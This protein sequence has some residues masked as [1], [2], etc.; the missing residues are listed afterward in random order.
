MSFHLLGTS[1]ETDLPEPIKARL[2]CHFLLTRIPDEGLPE[3]LESL[4]GMWM[5]YQT[6]TPH[7]P[8]LP[9]ARSVP[10]RLTGSYAEPVY[11]VTED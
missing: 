2:L 10:A 3:A 7:P 9:S 8:A 4:A 5:F 6:P 11:P 1:G